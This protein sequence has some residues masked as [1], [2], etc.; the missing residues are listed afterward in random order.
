MGSYEKLIK[1]A[2]KCREA[3]KRTRGEMSLIWLTHALK[4]EEKAES[5]LIKNA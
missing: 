5:L 1:K 3:A 2:I 4:L